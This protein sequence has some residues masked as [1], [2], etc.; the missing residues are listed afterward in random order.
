MDGTF[1]YVTKQ[2][3]SR[4]RELLSSESDTSRA[5]DL[6]KLL[7]EEEDKLGA[8]SERLEDIDQE[9]AKGDKRIAW[10]RTLVAAMER[11]GRDAAVAKALLENLTQIQAMYQQYR[12]ALLAA[13]DRNRL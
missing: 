13:I 1:T 11:D 3:V 9:I 2:N 12:Q 5:A 7:I 4:F 8:S 6:V 10:Q